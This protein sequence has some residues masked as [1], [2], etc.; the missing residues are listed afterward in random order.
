MQGMA[1]SAPGRLCDSEVIDAAR[2]VKEASPMC[3]KT[4]SCIGALVL[5]A[6]QMPETQMTS[7]DASAPP[8]TGSPGRPPPSIMA[9]ADAGV[10]EAGAE[11]SPEAMAAPDAGATSLTVPGN[12]PGVGGP[13]QPAKSLAPMPTGAFPA[14]Q[15]GPI[16][17]YACRAPYAGGIHG[18]KAFP[19]GNCNF[20]WGGREVEA[21]AYEVLIG[22]SFFWQPATAPLTSIPPDAI[23]SGQDAGGGVLHVCRAAHM[24]G[25]HPGKVVAGYCN[26]GFGGV[27]LSLSIFD[28]LL[29]MPPV[30]PV[31]PFDRANWTATASSYDLAHAPKN[32]FDGDPATRWSTGQ[33][34]AGNEWFRLDLGAAGTIGQVTLDT[35]NHP[36]DFPVRYAVELSTDDV[37]Y[38]AAAAGAGAGAVLKIKLTPTAARYVRI[39]Q[40]GQRPPNTE[41]WSI[42]EL[43]VAGE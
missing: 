25:V 14:G 22:A 2:F 4:I 35:Q 8:P 6:C 27:E 41:W 11:A 31:N 1:M 36:W 19:S 33:S 10:A 39:K 26:I 24:G 13:W 18:G 17:L 9:N 42:D 7:N 20:G 37:T 38:Q 28:I 29:T 3:K 32:A 23:A 15:E 43:T 21:S 34:Q 16:T 12:N 30:K 40:S 5:S